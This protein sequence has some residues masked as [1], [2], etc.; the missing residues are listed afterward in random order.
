MAVSPPFQ[1]RRRPTGCSARG[2]R[3]IQQDQWDLRAGELFVLGLGQAGEHGYHT[4]RAVPQHALQPGVRGG[5][6]AAQI[7]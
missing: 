6:V 1:L 4:A 3:R 2:A 7:R 5:A